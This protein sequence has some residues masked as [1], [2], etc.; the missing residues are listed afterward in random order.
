M[1]VVLAWAVQLSDLLSI[2]H[3]ENFKT[4]TT[5][6]RHFFN[7][8]IALSLT[9]LDDCFFSFMLIQLNKAKAAWIY[10]NED[11]N[12]NRNCIK[13]MKHLYRPINLAI[14]FFSPMLLGTT[15]FPWVIFAIPASYH[16]K[17]SEDR[18]RQNIDD[19]INQIQYESVTLYDTAL[20]NANHG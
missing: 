16:A 1:Q 9:W 19:K 10:H 13:V 15:L 17:D 7:V 4:Y 3:L 6:L 2:S 12:K 5:F 18:K 20:K 11:H 14:A 8:D